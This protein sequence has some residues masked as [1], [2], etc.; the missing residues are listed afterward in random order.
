[1]LITIDDFVVSEEKEITE[2]SLNPKIYNKAEKENISNANCKN[3]QSHK[4][5]G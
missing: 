2:D 3:C 4:R 5:Y 1:M